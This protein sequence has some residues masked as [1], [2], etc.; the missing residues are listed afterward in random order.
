MTQAYKVIPPN[1]AT[2]LGIAELTMV[3]L[4]AAKNIA[5][6]R[7]I[8]TDIFFLCDN[9]STIS[10]SSL[11]YLL[12]LILQVTNLDYT[13]LHAFPF[14]N[15]QFRKIIDVKRALAFKLSYDKLKKEIDFYLSSERSPV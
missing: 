11:F 14:F 12:L 2:I 8:M 6:I 9:S 10:S 7:A 4:I 5:A 3:W 1:S 13:K 15:N